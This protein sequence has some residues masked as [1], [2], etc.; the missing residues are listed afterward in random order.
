VVTELAVLKKTGNAGKTSEKLFR[1]TDS[2]YILR[3]FAL[4]RENKV[5]LH[6]K[7]KTKP[8][9][10]GKYSNLGQCFEPAVADDY[11]D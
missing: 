1:N 5:R 10:F 11:M 3:L 2:Y 7:E 8:H 9:S 6:V 4:S